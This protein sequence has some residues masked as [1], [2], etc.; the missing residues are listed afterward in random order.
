MGK[1]FENFFACRTDGVLLGIARW[2]PLL[3][4]EGTNGFPRDR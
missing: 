1:G 4:A 3:A 2:N